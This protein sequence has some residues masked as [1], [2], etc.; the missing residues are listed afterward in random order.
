MK[1]AVLGVGTTGITSLSY[2]L[3]QLDKG[4]QIYSVHNPA[5]PI[6]GIGESTTVEIPRNLFCGTRFSLV[7]DA[8]H[9]DATIKHAVLYVG[10]RQHDFFSQIIPP[11]YGIH[12]NN[13]K[14]KDF[15][16]GRFR[17]IW[18]QKFKV[19][20]GE[21]Q[22]IH[23]SSNRV[24][25]VVDR[26][27]HHFDYIV[28][29]MGYPKEYDGYDIVDSVPI[30]SCLVNTIPKPGLWDWTYHVAHRNGWMFGI[31]L[32]TRQGW[33]YLYNDE[34]TSDEDAIDDFAERFKIPSRKLKVR[35]FKFRR[36]RAKRFIE[37]RIVK[38]GNRALFYEPL[39]ALSGSFYDKIM[40]HFC[41]VLKGEI[42]E[43]TANASLA[44]HARDY[45]N[46]ICY[47]YHGGSTYRTQF[48]NVT[49]RRCA[50]K[51][52]GDER[53]QQQMQLLRKRKP[54]DQCDNSPVC[55]LG[56]TSWFD[57]DRNFGHYQLRSRYAYQEREV[58]NGPR[59]TM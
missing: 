3:S 39:E 31:P 28:D 8:V 1:I 7:R 35:G 33:G 50:A 13:F 17:E 55:V 53:F 14:L 22:D 37:G 20:E 24:T 4:C 34:L 19:I 6:L 57:F 48:W 29:C 36:Y 12:F 10:W 25:L 23:E 45:E 52:R 2:L 42:D 47:I 32:T 58:S 59:L 54:S 5:V 30:N 46:L 26:K 44:L 43:P 40:R 56:A 9:L 21:V 15:A 49:S 16:F 18:G 11:S 27:K 51:I 38:N 41:A